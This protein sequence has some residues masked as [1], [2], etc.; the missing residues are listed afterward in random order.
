VLVNNFFADLRMTTFL[1]AFP[2]PSLRRRQSTNRFLS[3]LFPLREKLGGL[4]LSPFFPFPPGRPSTRVR[5]LFAPFF[6]FLEATCRGNAASPFFSFSEARPT[7]VRGPSVWR[8]F[9]KKKRKFFFFFLFR[10][11]NHLFGAASDIPFPAYDA[12]SFGAN[13]SFSIWF[14]RQG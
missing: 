11:H 8:L 2:P 1:P 5:P 13:F 14:F 7:G 9:P 6:F 4:P 3:N 10:L 12:F